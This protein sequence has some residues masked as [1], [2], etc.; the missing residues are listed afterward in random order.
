M[1]EKQKKRKV[2]E[3]DIAVQYILLNFSSET[4]NCP[5]FAMHDIFL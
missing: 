4:S 2:I 1:K 3:I 5:M